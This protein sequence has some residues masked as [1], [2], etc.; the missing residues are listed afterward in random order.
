M[1]RILAVIAI[2]VTAHAGP[3]SA[4]DAASADKDAAPK[5]TA[6]NAP[7]E[8]FG[9]ALPIIAAVRVERKQPSPVKAARH[10]R[11][12]TVLHASDL[13][14]EDSAH[15]AF[16]ALVGMEV[17]RTVYAGAVINHS[18]IGPPTL[19]ERNAIVS[20]EFERGPLLITTEGRALDAGAEGDMVR[21]MNLAS[22]IILSAQVVGPNK[23]KTQ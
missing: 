18:N 22:K 3:A 9:D 12:G 10:L 16:A 20:L 4:E 14:S 15:D 23:V 2:A 1:Q 7:H 8:A 6:A 13:V 5:N 21:V 17:K 11:A 19:I